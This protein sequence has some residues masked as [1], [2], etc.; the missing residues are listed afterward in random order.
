MEEPLEE[1]YIKN[2]AVLP[3][4]RQPTPAPIPTPHPRSNSGPLP[5]EEPLKIHGYSV[6][7]YKRIY[8]SEVDPMMT[9]RSGHPR[10]YSLQMGRVIKQRLWD[11]FSCPSFLE[12][13]DA[14]GRIWITESYC[15][16]TLEPYAPLIEV[17]IIG[18]P[19]PVKPKRKRAR[20]WINKMSALTYWTFPL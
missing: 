4:F 14:D 6:E 2:A 20:R 18:E 9:T 16:P 3:D 11:K 15:S 17:D 8:H 12:T 7:E 10:P 1:R 19:M 5:Q 13:E